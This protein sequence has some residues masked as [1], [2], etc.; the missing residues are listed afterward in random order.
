MINLN[1]SSRCL[2][3]TQSTEKF[4]NEVLDTMDK[5]AFVAD[6]IHIIPESFKRVLIYEN[7]QKIPK[8]KL[9]QLVKDLESVFDRDIKRYI[10]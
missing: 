2:K 8:D 9:H 7:L 10:D 3:M 4:C 5:C 6:N 1:S